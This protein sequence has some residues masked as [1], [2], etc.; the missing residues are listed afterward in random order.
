MSEA[1]GVSVTTTIEDDS[2]S[3]ELARLARA[4]KNVDPALEE[5]GSSQ[6]TEVQWRFEQA[7]GPDGI[8]WKS[9]ADI[10]REAREK[11]GATKPQILR[12]TNNLYDSVTYK[13]LPGEATQI[14]TNKAY[15]RIHQF[16]GL[17]G[18]GLKVEIPARPYLGLSE[19]GRQE[20]LAIL[21]D[22]IAR[23]S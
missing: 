9:L 15:A 3:P 7:Q 16:G 23:Q 17:A 13:V 4:I 5:I 14:G 2:I 8:A 6:V 12:D 22:H 19:S 11:K 21:R 18:R 20:V 1:V 10:T